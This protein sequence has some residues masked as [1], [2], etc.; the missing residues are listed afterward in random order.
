MRMHCGVKEFFIQEFFISVFMSWMHIWR[1]YL[2]AYLDESGFYMIYFASSRRW[3]G[4]FLPA[5]GS[6]LMGANYHTRLPT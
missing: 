4:G 6:S 5:E 3:A 1:Q 2:E